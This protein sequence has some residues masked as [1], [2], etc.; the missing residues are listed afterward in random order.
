MGGQMEV[1][2]NPTQV[3]G[4]TDQQTEGRRKDGWTDG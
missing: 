4:E 2:D 1:M 3:G